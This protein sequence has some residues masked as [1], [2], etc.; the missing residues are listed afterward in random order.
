MY[1]LNSLKNFLAQI[2]VYLAK[3]FSNP[4]L[5]Y[6]DFIGE[7][8][9]LLAWLHSELAKNPDAKR[10]ETVIQVF[11]ISVT[12]VR[13]LKLPDLMLPDF[14]KSL[15][16]DEKSTVSLQFMRDYIQVRNQGYS[17]GSECYLLLL[18]MV[19]NSHLAKLNELSLAA[20]QAIE[21][22]LI[23]LKP[24]L[25][26]YIK[27]MQN[28]QNLV[29]VLPFK[30]RTYGTISG[31]SL[32]SVISNCL[33]NIL[34]CKGSYD[35]ALSEA[36]IFSIADNWCRF[37]ST[38]VNEVKVEEEKSPK[39]LFKKFKAKVRDD[40]D[41]HMQVCR[42]HSFFKRLSANSKSKRQIAAVV[43]FFT[44]LCDDDS[45]MDLATLNK[46]ILGTEDKPTFI[47]KILLQNQIGLAPHLHEL[48]Y[49]DAPWHYFD[50][51]D[52]QRDVV[53][54]KLKI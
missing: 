8:A 54:T 6:F 2:D 18:K 21:V 25:I 3:N 40:A 13:D 20:S 1:N 48:L 31:D 37:F 19:A 11:F 29:L 42:E 9:A 41:E 12:N 34:K 4:P 26:A 15:E 44:T 51:F 23:Q 50:T 36:H 22:E 53:L 10:L 28:M 47:R 16:I 24:L 30:E 35:D 7:Y 49:K 45:V 32:Q 39:N 5:R 46:A 43:E 14:R 52:E 17:N 27:F 33:R 38:I